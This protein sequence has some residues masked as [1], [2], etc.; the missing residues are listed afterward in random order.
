MPPTL[1]RKVSGHTCDRTP[2][3]APA[4][5]AIEGMTIQAFGDEGDDVAARLI[6]SG[7]E[8]PVPLLS[9]SHGRAAALFGIRRVQYLH[10]FGW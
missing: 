1:P 2:A 10:R 9:C 7:A 8:A 4:E 5:T 3:R 6:S